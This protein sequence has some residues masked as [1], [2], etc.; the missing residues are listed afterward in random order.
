MC[1]DNEQ[2]EMRWEKSRWSSEGKS[3]EG[4]GR[5]AHKL[6]QQKQ[7]TLTA[8]QRRPWGDNL[9]LRDRPDEYLVG[10]L[11]I[12][13]L[14]EKASGMKNFALTE[15]M[16]RYGFA[17]IGLTQP[18]RRWDLI[19]DEDHFDGRFRAHFPCQQIRPVVGYNRHDKESRK[20]QWGGTAMMT[21][22]EA[23]AKVGQVGSDKQGLGRWTWQRMRGK[24]G[25]SIRIV[26]VYRPSGRGKTESVA[27][28]HIRYFDSIKRNVEPIPAFFEDL[29][30]EAQAWIKEGDQLVVMGDFNEDVRGSHLRDFFGQRGLGMRE[31]IVEKHGGKGPET[32]LKNESNIPIDGIF[33]TPGL[34]IL[35]GGYL[36]YCDGPKTD[37]RLLWIRLS[38]QIAFGHLGPKIQP[39]FVRRLNQKDPRGKKKYKDEVREKIRKKKTIESL[40]KLLA[41]AT[42]PPTAQQE[43]EFERIDKEL[44][45]IRLAAQQSVRK[46]YLGLPSSPPI[47]R[48]KTAI[49]LVQKL[50]DRKLKPRC[51]VHQKTLMRLAKQSGK[52]DW[53]QPR[54]LADLF[55]L[56]SQAYREYY[57]S[58]PNAAM[59]RRTHVED[60]AQAQADEGNKDVAKTLNSNLA[61]AELR[62]KHRRMKRIRPRKKGGGID[63][64]ITETPRL[65]ERGQQ[66]YDEKDDPIMDQHVCS[67]NDEIND[68]AAKE[69]ENRSRMSEDTDAMTSPLR[70]LLGYD[71]MTQFG[72]Q[73]L[74]G[75]YTEPSGLSDA[76]SLL[77]PELVALEPYRSGPPAPAWFSLDSYKSG[78]KGWIR[79]RTASGPSNL[80]PA[81]FRIEAEDEE[82]V[83]VGYLAAHFPWLTGYSPERW[84]HGIDL[85]IQKKI[86]SFLA[87]GLR[88]ILLFDV[89]ANMHNKRLG[90]L[91][92]QRAE[93][94]GGL[95]P[96][97]YGSRKHKAADVQALNTR[98]FFDYVRLRRCH[99]VAEFIDLKSNYDLVVH[100]IASLCMQ[101]VGAPKEPIICTLTTLQDMKHAVRTAAGDSDFRYGGELWVIPIRPPPQGLGQGNG[102]APAIWAVVSTPVLNMLRKKG[103]GAAFKCCISGEELQLVGYAFVDDTT[104]TTLAATPEE[105][106]H[107]VVDRSQRSTDLYIAGMR[108]T[109]GKAQP[110]KT[111]CYGMEIRWR[112]G[113]WSYSR[114]S[115]PLIDMATPRGRRSI[116]RLPVNKAM[117][118]LGVMLAPDGNSRDQVKKLRSITEEWA[119]AVKSRH[120]RNDEAWEYYQTTV[121]KTLEYP[122]AATT[123]SKRQCTEIEAPAL[124]AGLQRSGM[125]ANLPRDLVNG[126]KTMQG[127]GSPDIYFVQGEKH[128]QVLLDHGHD[129]SI[130]GNHLRAGIEAHKLELGVGGSLF[131]KDYNMFTSYMT[132]DTW[133]ANTWKFLWEYR[134]R[135]EE[136]TPSLRLQREGD[137]FLMEAFIEAGYQGEELA[138]LNRCR[139]FLQVV[140]VADISSGDGTKLLRST[141][142]KRTDSPSARRYQ[143][144]GQGPPSQQA[145]TTWE[146][147]ISK[148]LLQQNS[149]RT[150]LRQSLGRWLVDDDDWPWLLEEQERRLYQKRKDGD[151]WNVF[152]SR[153]SRSGRSVG[154]NFALQARSQQ[155]PPP[156]AM[157][158]RVESRGAITVYHTGAAST[159]LSTPTPPPQSLAH[160]ILSPR[161]GRSWATSKWL[162]DDDGAYIAKCIRDETAKAVSDGSFK[163]ALGTA[164]FVLEGPIEEQHW[165]IGTNRVPGIAEDQSAYRSELAG[166]YAIACTVEDLCE[167]HNITRGAVTIACDGESA[168]YKSMDEQHRIKSKHKHFDL[169]MAI[170]SKLKTSP[171]T[172]HWRHVHGHQDIKHGITFEEMD[173]WAQLNMIVDRLAGERWNDEAAN[174]DQV[175]QEIENEGWRAYLQ[176]TAK[177]EGMIA[178]L[179]GGVKMSNKLIDRLE[180][181][182]LGQQSIDYWVEHNHFPK[183]YQR[184]IDWSMIGLA[185]SRMSHLRTAFVTKFVA[186]HGATASRLFQREQVAS[187]ECPRGC[188]ATKEDSRHVLK[189]PRGNETWDKLA[190]IL[191][192][193]GRKNDMEPKLMKAL[194]MG[195]T[196]W[197]QGIKT[198]GSIISRLGRE[199]NAA[200]GDQSRI[201]WACVLEGRLSTQW[202]GIQTRYLQTIGSRASPRR[203]IAAL[204]TKLY[205]VAW[206]LWQLRNFHTNPADSPADRKAIA[207]LQVRLK[208][209]WRRNRR[210]LPKRY[211]FLFED[212]LEELL[213]KPTYYQRT[214]LRTVVNALSR[215]WGEDRINRDLGTDGEILGLWIRGKVGRG[216]KL[217]PK[218][219]TTDRKLPARQRAIRRVLNDGTVCETYAEYEHQVILQNSHSLWQ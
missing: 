79:E 174:E 71:A 219:R 51:R 211:R 56:R 145:W 99:A 31:V 121:R 44:T 78:W 173:R 144:P 90:R 201:G 27:A 205:D 69:V 77:L 91:L 117:E 29:K 106:F 6:A 130:T 74:A 14:P 137:A 108:V 42:S 170:K 22:G 164:A 12:A 135:V 93:E 75:T 129:D 85:L 41:E 116:E 81:M 194:V 46:I 169:I 140:T 208:H 2:V 206:D 58:K 89:D 33:C 53:L 86:G 209:H 68:G 28:Q 92:L 125:P 181:V 152:V 54:T 64:L 114:S 115:S 195:V 161:H 97:Q 55:Q 84:R 73:I 59:L 186:N 47:K 34:S 172:W 175:Q 10:C 154:K 36:P 16:R 32:C 213:A 5:D 101:R 17:T 146:T 96:E 63:T 142:H 159:L 48:S 127:L 185:A 40:E 11:N 197:R 105:P 66:V 189:C 217:P 184:H 134:I 141:K 60:L 202:L 176:P 171:I 35:A 182:C 148:C 7:K 212:P 193:W 49:L 165:I 104:K 166:I 167:H 39:H 190:K 52:E 188:G 43:Q 158:T 179:D 9:V 61:R 118:I 57:I 178:S 196:H 1:R 98:L 151:G 102:A 183:R 13:G 111:K 200:Y 150:C 19:P 210:Y 45:E 214:W 37:H 139:M 83:K 30:N 123:L 187:P 80:T 87:S 203:L 65:D 138:Q 94:C 110:K 112:G 124:Q 204:I 72:D 157:R 62:E 156:T 3:A 122:L 67:N 180:T 23:A 100:S 132:K 162:N 199:V 198:K 163:D 192:S 38:A 149:K 82:L 15:M 120:V 113:K 153:S 143:W 50:I 24:A 119:S 133:C 70:D 131:T 177:S 207:S 168:L 191:I 128:L 155:P 95:A 8:N 88:P 126:P 216:R 25:A 160:R 20:R 103:Y 136:R 147:A 18:D 76:A 218:L 109:G 107:C 26:T 21:V 215:I 4:K